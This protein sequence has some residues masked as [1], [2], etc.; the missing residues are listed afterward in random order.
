AG[1]AKVISLIIADE[2]CVLTATENG[3]GKRTAVDQYPSHG[4]GGQGVISI[5]GGE[6]NGAVVGAVLVSEEEQIMLISDGGTLV[7]TRVTEI[8]VL[9][10]NTQG[11]RLIKLSNGEKLV[12]IERVAETEEDDSD[13]VAE[14]S[15]ED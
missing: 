1:D 9:G 5:Q 7:R 14:V 8:S 12:G 4:R 6:R 13:E 15:S 10:R 11:V 2:G 3:Y